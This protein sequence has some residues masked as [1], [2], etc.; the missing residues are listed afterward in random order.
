MDRSRI[1]ESKGLNDFAKIGVPL[2]VNVKFFLL[3]R[4]PLIAL[5]AYTWAE[6]VHLP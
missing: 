3:I 2:D 4:S 1:D 5:Y 6:S